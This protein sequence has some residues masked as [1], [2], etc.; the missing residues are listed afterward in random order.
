MK[1]LKHGALFNGIGGFPLAA[2]WNNIETVWHS[3]IDQFCNKV[4]DKHFPHSE[5]LGDIKNVT[6]QTARSIDI[7][8]G[9]FPCQPYSLAGKRKGDQDDRALWKEMFRVIQ[10]LKPTWVIGENVPGIIGMVLDNVLADLASEG[11]ESQTFIIPAC[12]KGAWHRRNRVWIISYNEKQRKR[13][14]SIQQRNKGQEGINTNRQN[15]KYVT[16][17]DS[18][19]ISQSSERITSEFTNKNGKK[20]RISTDTKSKRQSGR[21]L[22]DDTGNKSENIES[23]DQ[24]R[25]KTFKYLWEWESEPR[26]GRVADGI[27]NRVDRLKSLGNA[28]VPQVAYEFFKIIKE[29]EAKCT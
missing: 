24:S 17:T 12:G 21:N 2:A 28:I 4:M 13:R 3:E 18:I 29:I 10:E 27:S 26:M 9:G 22:R 11:Y 14:L 15:K 6:K 20:G 1:N 23:R 16:N 7:L 19:G 5:N 25:S 8:S